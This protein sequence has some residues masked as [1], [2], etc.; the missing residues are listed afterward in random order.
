[1][2]KVSQEKKNT[3]RELRNRL[4]DLGETLN[5]YQTHLKELM[6]GRPLEGAAMIFAA[7]LISGI[8]VGAVR[9]RHH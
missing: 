3:I 8:L 1:M 9:S 2:N 6:Y 7:G 5:N 4:G